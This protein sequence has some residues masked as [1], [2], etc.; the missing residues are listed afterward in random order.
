MIRTLVSVVATAVISAACSL[1]VSPTPVAAAP[2]PT[3]TRAEIIARAESAV[4]TA[5]TWG[6]ESWN[7]D[8][9]AGAGP[10]CSGLILKCWEV[11]RMMLYQEE[12]GVNSSISPRYTT[13][14]FL[15]NSG[16]WFSLSSRSQ[17]LSGDI[18]VRHV[19]G[20]GHV[21]LY[22]EGDAWGYP[23]VYEAPCT[24]SNV[25]RASRYLNSEYQPRRRSYLTEA[26]LLLDNPTAKSTG[27]DDVG[28]NWTRSTS[29]PGYYGQN[30]QV[31]AATTATA[32]AR[33]TPRIP[34]AGYYNVY[35]RWTD[36]WN[37]AT[38]TKVTINTAWG[39]NVKYVNQ[40]VNGGIWYHLGR[41]YMNAGYYPGSGSVA[42]HATG[43]NG[44]VVADA[45]KFVRSP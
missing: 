12:D 34:A 19:N 26:G 40:R 45:A 35:I 17:L 15:Y 22:A 8:T 7:P 5:Y 24:G 31:R 10:D 33:W 18:M 29:N 32:W 39:Q 21:V 37:R 2:A 36:G 14:E 20:A 1:L 11:P 43:A 4:G 41:Y 25:R 23:I 6:R 16:P 44:Y 9:M 13:G 27:G 38:N 28:G 3:M 30:Y 42:V